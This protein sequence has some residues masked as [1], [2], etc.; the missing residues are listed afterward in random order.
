MEDSSR[1]LCIL[2]A[3]NNYNR[4]IKIL[5]KTKI[6]HIPCSSSAEGVKCPSYALTRGAEQLWLEGS[7]QERSIR[8]GTKQQEE[9]ANWSTTSNSQRLDAR[10]G[11]DRPK[12]WPMFGNLQEA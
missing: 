12:L 9:L 4:T 5:E 8:F 6:T 1:F 3:L 7:N 11:E 10:V 2:A